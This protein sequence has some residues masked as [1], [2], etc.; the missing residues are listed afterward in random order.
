MSAWRDPN[1]VKGERRPK[2]Q[3]PAASL[4]GDGGGVEARAR[5]KEVPK[6]LGP[7]PLKFLLKHRGA[8]S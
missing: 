1:S 3:A 4:K 6:D 7:A 5:V 8:I 2:R